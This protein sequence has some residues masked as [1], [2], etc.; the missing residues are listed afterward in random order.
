MNSL[1]PDFS[2]SQASLIDIL[3]LLMEHRHAQNNIISCSLAAGRFLA[4][5]N[6]SPL[7]TMDNQLLTRKRGPVHDYG[8]QKRYRQQPTQLHRHQRLVQ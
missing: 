1:L 7:R 8:Y 4:W 6:P 2:I 5:T 3:A